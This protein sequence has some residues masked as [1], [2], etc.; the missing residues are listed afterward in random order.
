MELSIIATLVIKPENVEHFI[1]D[2]AKNL[3]ELSRKEPGCLKYDLF[4]DQKQ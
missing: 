3:V 4:R 1:N 2:I